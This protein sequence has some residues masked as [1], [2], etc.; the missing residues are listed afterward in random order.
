[1]F[2]FLFSNCKLNIFIYYCQYPEYGFLGVSEKIQL[3]RHNLNSENV[4]ERLLPID[5]MT[6]GDL[7]EVVLPGE[8]LHA[9]YGIIGRMLGHQIT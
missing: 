5:A 6:E 7:I 9:L 8:N 1:M 4:L 3:F 2:I